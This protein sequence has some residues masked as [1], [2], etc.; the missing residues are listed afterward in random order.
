MNHTSWSDSILLQ[1]HLLGSHHVCIV[2]IQ[3]DIKLK[4]LIYC[5]HKLFSF[6]QK[7]DKILVKT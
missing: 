1:E 2:I 3:A 4:C 5:V 7:F 6:Y